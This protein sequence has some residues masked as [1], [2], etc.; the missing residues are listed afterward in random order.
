MGTSVSLKKNVYLC[1]SYSNNMY[2]DSLCRKINK[3]GFQAIADGTELMPGERILSVAESIIK[4]DYFVLII[5]DEFSQHMREE[6]RTALKYEKNVMVF[7]K[8]EL[9]RDEE[10]N[11]EFKD[12]LVTLWNNE[13]EL[14]MKVMTAMVGVR[15]KY[16]ERGYLLEVLVEN[17]FKSYGCVT[18][19]TAYTQDS[20]FDICAEKDGKKFYIE[21]RAVRSKIISKASIASTIVAADMMSLK[22]D[23][24]FV[25]VTPNVIP[26]LVQEYIRTKD[27][28][29][30]I[31]ISELLY[32]VQDNEELK[33]RLLSLIEFTTE[34]IELKEPEEFLRM[35]DVVEDETLDSIID[36]NERIKQLLQEVND[37]EQDKKTS[38]EYE[39]FCTKVLKILFSNDLT[40]WR[41]QQKS[42]DDLYRFDLICKIKDDVTSAFWKFIEEYFRSKY[43]I[44]EFKNYKDVITQKEIYTTEK[45]L[46]AKALRCVAII[47]SC[48][49]SD[50]N[51]KK[52]IKGTLR[53][54]GKLILNLSNKD[55][56]NMLEY[57]L[58]GNLAS[59]YLYNVLDEMLIELEK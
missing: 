33:Y 49:G 6:Y 14:S 48:N 4:C 51:A 43:I 13:N 5:S 57:E 19:R 1:Y 11:R 2:I 17:L 37:W 28:F 22:N 12:R 52:A 42:N 47:V 56:A 45:Y 20:G 50:E 8:S 32:L 38:A 24:Y 26:N 9:Y 54:N 29:L 59:E 46:Y 30:V 40:L 25:L 31:D 36:D 21:V 10:I 27:K 3:E 16:P 44:F 18:R 35:L 7:I 34:D 58:N 41:E 55:I 23:E 39:K 53:E 15:Y